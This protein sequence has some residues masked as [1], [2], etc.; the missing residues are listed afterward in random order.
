MFSE[1]YNRIYTVLYINSTVLSFKPTPKLPLPIKFKPS[2]RREYST[3]VTGTP[4][5]CLSPHVLFEIMCQQQLAPAEAVP[6]LDVCGAGPSRL[7]LSSHSA[8]DESVTTESSPTELLDEGIEWELT[9]SHMSA[10]CSSKGL[11]LLPGS[12]YGS[13]KH[14][15]ENANHPGVNHNMKYS[16][17]LR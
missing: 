11:S 10:S 2:R 9:G 4:C 1:N 17:Y 12:D 8:R 7:S 16:E 3:Q 6:R 5:F 13:Q 15:K 14:K